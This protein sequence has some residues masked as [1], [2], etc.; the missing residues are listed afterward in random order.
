MMTNTQVTIKIITIGY[1]LTSALAL[2]SVSVMALVNPQSV[3]DLVAVKLNNNDAISSI[4]GVY[5]GLGITVFVSLIYMLVTQRL[6]GLVFLMMLWGFYAV[7]RFLTS[8]VEGPLG[9]F[10]TTWFYIE[11]TLAAIAS[12]LLWAHFKF[13]V[14]R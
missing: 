4:R 5:G 11:L 6:Q 9:S 14:A 12:V 7:S 8:Q 1:I 13:K 2:L 10:G 3:M